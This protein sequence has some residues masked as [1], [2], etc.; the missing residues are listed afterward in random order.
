MPWVDHVFE[1]VI[2]DDS[3]VNL[4]KEGGIYRVHIE[5]RTEREQVERAL[6][7]C[8]SDSLLYYYAHVIHR[9]KEWEMR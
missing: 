5:R 4:K 8:R 9:I 3:S 2:F 7:R 6:A 1:K